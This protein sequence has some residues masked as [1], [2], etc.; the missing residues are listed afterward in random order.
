M[1]NLLL[2]SIMLARKHHHHG[3][4]YKRINDPIAIVLKLWF[5]RVVMVS[6]SGLGTLLWD[7]LVCYGVTWMVTV[8]RALVVG[9]CCSSLKVKFFP[10]P[11]FHGENMT[12]QILFDIS[13][14]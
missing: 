8:E 1:F 5:R 14:Q 10:I 7:L 2:D 12:F 6:L 3:L 11:N 4:L 9:F 13:C